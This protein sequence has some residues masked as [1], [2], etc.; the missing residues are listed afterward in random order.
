MLSQQKE[1]F[2]TLRPLL[3]AKRAFQLKSS[4][5]KSFNPSPNREYCSID[6]LCCSFRTQ[7]FDIISR[8]DF[9]HE[10]EYDEILRVYKGF[11]IKKFKHMVYVITFND[12]VKYLRPGT[13]SSLL[14]TSFGDVSGIADMDGA[15]L[16]ATPT[17]SLAR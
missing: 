15:D 12:L 14:S 7:R 5:W 3:L 13:L 10:S 16:L 8:E 4:W 11:P 17:D 2:A 1:S 6:I 9:V